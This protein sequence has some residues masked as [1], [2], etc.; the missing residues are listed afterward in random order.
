[1]YTTDV[2]NEKAQKLLVRHD[3]MTGWYSVI[4]PIN[5]HQT[6]SWPELT[7]ISKTHNTRPRLELLTHSGSN[8]YP[9]GDPIVLCEKKA[10]EFVTWQQ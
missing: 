2:Q 10:I 4:L 9:K 5:I 8:P 1:M 3:N 7:Y 6:R